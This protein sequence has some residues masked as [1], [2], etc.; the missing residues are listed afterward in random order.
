[1]PNFTTI[2]DRA[3]GLIVNKQ[4]DTNLILCELLKVPQMLAN[5][6]MRIMEHN[7]Y[8]RISEEMGGRISIYEVSAKLRRAIR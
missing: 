4:A 5:H 6:I 8:L 7:G 2:V 1:V 3:A